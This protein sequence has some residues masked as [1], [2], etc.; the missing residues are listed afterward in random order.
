MS[1]PAVAFAMLLGLAAPRGAAQDRADPLHDLAVHRYRPAGTP[2]GGVIMLSGDGGWRSFD[3]ATADS[4]RPMGYWVVGLDCLRLFRTEMTRDS[5]AHLVLRVIA[6]LRPRLPAGAPVYLVG[7]SFGA[8]LVADAA[9]SR[10]PADGLILLGPGERG[11]RKVTLAGFLSREP[12]GATSYDTAARLNQRGCLPAAFVTAEQDESG[13]GASVFAR[14]HAPAAQFLV[15]GAGHHYR[16]G[17]ARYAAALR[18]ALAWLDSARTTCVTRGA[19][20]T[21]VARPASHSLTIQIAL[22][23]AAGRV[24]ARSADREA[25]IQLGSLP[26]KVTSNIGMLLLGIWL[27]LAG[28]I[29]LLDLSFR[30]LG[31][32]TAILALVAGGLIIVGR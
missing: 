1:R 30:G 31:T 14:T 32:V 23:L 11:V 18:R 29:P 24:A 12:R 6:D 19:A 4:L 25:V 10:V 17:D 8:D 21:G 9:G 3:M 5:L 27:V 26:M 2:R 13:K 15:P 7:Y 28:L 16:G 22:C 20:H